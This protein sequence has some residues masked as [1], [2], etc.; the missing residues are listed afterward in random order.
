RDFGDR[1]TEYFWRKDKDTRG[2]RTLLR[3]TR[4]SVTSNLGAEFSHEKPT[5]SYSYGTASELKTTSPHH[6]LE[7]SKLRLKGLKLPGVSDTG[8]DRV[9][10]SYESATGRVTK[11]TL[12]GSPDIVWT[13]EQQVLSGQEPTA[14]PATSVSVK[15]PWGHEVTHKL[16]GEEG[17][18]D[19]RDHVVSFKAP[20]LESGAE[21]PKYDGDPSDKTIATAFTYKDDG[22]LESKTEKL[23]DTIRLV[24]SFD[25]QV[26]PERLANANVTEKRERAFVGTPSAPTTVLRTTKFEYSE[27]NVLSS[28]EDP[29]RRVARIPVPSANGSGVASGYDSEHVS[30]KSDFDAHARATSWQ[31]NSGSNSPAPVTTMEFDADA[32]GRPGKGYPKSLKKGG[33][34]V[35]DYIYDKLG[36]LQLKDAYGAVSLTVYDEWDRPKSVAAGGSSGQYAAVESFVE[37]GFD[38]AGHLAIEKERLDGMG[39]DGRV[40]TTHVY[41]DREQ[42]ESVTNSSLAD[43]TGALVDAKTTYGYDE[44]GRLKTVTSPAGVVTTYE[45]DNAGRIASESTGSGKKRRMYDE[46]DRVVFTTDGDV[47]VWRGKHNGFGEL[48]EEKLPTGSKITRTFDDSGHVTSEQLK[49]DKDVLLSKTDYKLTSWGEVEKTT[50]HLLA[51]A[52]QPDLLRVTVNTYDTNGR[53]QKVRVGPSDDPATAREELSLV[54]DEQSR[55]TARNTPGGNLELFR[56]GARSHWPDS[57]LFAEG[58]SDK[59][60][61][62]FFRKRD[63]FG[64]VIEA[65]RSDGLSVTTTYDQH[66]NVRSKTSGVGT[67]FEYTYDGAGKLVSMTAPSG[68][69]LNLGYDLDGRLRNRTVNG[70]GSAWLTQYH[71]DLAHSGRPLD[72]TYPDGSS[73]QYQDYAPD[74]VLKKWKNRYGHTIV[75]EVDAANRLVSMTPSNGPGG[76]KTYPM[77]WTYDGAS[78]I[79]KAQKIGIA[80]GDIETPT[81]DLGGRPGTTTLGIGATLLRNF[82][83][84]DN[85]K[86]I[87]AL[88]GFAGDGL[89]K[90]VRAFDDLDRPTSSMLGESGTVGPPL[91]KIGWTGLASLGLVS[92]EAG[93]PL[94]VN[95]E[96]TSPGRLDKISFGSTSASWGKLGFGYRKPD[97]YKQSRTAAGT[98]PNGGVFSNQGWGYMPDNALRL[99]RGDA[100]SLENFVY[101]YGSRDELLSITEEK[102]AKGSDFKADVDGRIFTR[103]G[104]RYPHDVMGNRIEDE[105]FLYS[106]SWRGELSSVQVKKTWPAIRA[107]QPAI[108][109]LYPDHKLLLEYDALGRLIS[110]KHV[111]ALPEGTTDEAARPFIQNREYLWE[112]ALRLAEVG[113]DQ[114]GAVVWRKTYVPGPTGQDDPVQMRVENYGSGTSTKTTKNYAFIRDEQSTVLGLIDEQAPANP[115]GPPVPVRYLYTPLGEAHVELGPELLRA[116]F[117]SALTHLNATN[118]LPPIPQQTIGGG[119]TFITSI[120][121]DPATLTDGVTIETCNGDFTSCDPVPAGVFAIAEQDEDATRLSVLPPNGWPKGKHYRLRL[122]ATLK[123]DL[124]RSFASPDGPGPF[125]VK[126]DVPGDGLTAPLYDRSFEF[127]YDTIK[128]ASETVDSR[129]PGGMNLLHGGSWTDPVSGLQYAGFAWYDPRSGEYLAERSDGASLSEYAHGGFIRGQETTAAAQYVAPEGST[130]VAPS[131]PRPAKVSA[132]Q[133]FGDVLET[134]ASIAV[135][136]IPGVWPVRAL[137]DAATSYE[138]RVGEGQGEI[139]SVV[140]AVIDQ[141]PLTLLF[142]KK[143]EGESGEGDGDDSLLC[144]A[145]ETL[146]LTPRGRVAARDIRVGQR[147]S[148]PNSD[149][150]GTETKVEQST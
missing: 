96:Y 29:L 1:D 119:V 135:D 22:R 101:G 61:E 52:G 76:V 6:G 45:Y 62:T 123:D 86:E 104:A 12:P 141:T 72:V 3:V 116:T 81:Y 145:E 100:G 108:T 131:A 32:S 17:L 148:T 94:Y 107:G 5:F 48:F 98:S 47:G 71:Y 28:V 44:F 93:G 51:E 36:N 42:L 20:T 83:T 109:P 85:P 64:R 68:G 27:A 128:A 10:L 16:K 118:Q 124:A 115:R 82:D 31:G 106:W 23:D 41:N 139:R 133:L 103:D 137:L 90:Y 134:G 138:E 110:R 8:K 38:A 18:P 39:G 78:R 87:S 88:G 114:N 58:G 50:E 9:A 136:F 43:P 75:N 40:T 65:Q 4:P 150:D 127:T 34:V 122:A 25:Y 89:A 74:D 60:V 111:G 11:L 113:K 37:R 70:A 56:Y 79:A 80:K 112:G 55:V 59:S 105:R 91:V 77:G 2:D 19:G 126:I 143:G 26:S 146:V 92:T 149:E 53:L 49:D 21:T 97:G 142:P 30:S 84:W 46:D 69:V 147:V 33:E 121:F 66:G 24:T 57:V 140:G 54:F 13:V 67:R 117:D 144:V 73:E 120:S 129:I 63:V 14:G 102:K 15:A 95:R 35:E 130:Y 125:E 132:S 99:K 7:F